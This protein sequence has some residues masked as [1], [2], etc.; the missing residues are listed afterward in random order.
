MSAPQVHVPDASIYESGE[1]LS[2]NPT[3]HV[4]DSEW[5]ASKVLKA[6][7]RLKIVPASFCEI[8]CGAG[9]VLRQLHSALPG[10]KF[11]GYEISPQA[12]ALARGRQV[13][14]LD[15]RLADILEPA[16]ERPHYD[17]ALAMDVFEHVEDYYSFLK[18]MKRLAD[19]KIFHIPLEWTIET[20]LRPKLFKKWRDEIGHLHF[21]NKDTA[22]LA[23]ENCGYQVLDWFY[24][25]WLFEIHRP[26]VG[27]AMRRWA[28]KSL[29]AINVD[30]GVRTLEGHS[31]LVSAQ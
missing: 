16:E 3:W 6:L 23:L 28:L 5:K 31:M 29:C 30:L 20:T 19:T 7:E 25:P 4:E 12:H 24:T 10:C 13:P 15:F 21:F 22:L 27:R 2:Q 1:Y 14:G 17:V 18:N 11:T 9:E 26:S 8:G